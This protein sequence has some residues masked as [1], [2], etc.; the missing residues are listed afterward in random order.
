MYGCA[1]SSRPPELDLAENVITVSD[2][3]LNDKH[4]ASDIFESVRLIPLETTD[5]SIIGE[6]NKIVIIDTLI[7]IMDSK[8]KAIMLFNTK[9][10]HLSKIARKGEGPNEYSDLDDFTVMKNGDIIILDYRKILH[11]KTDGMHYKTY[12]TEFHADAI[13]SINDSLFVCSGSREKDIIVW[14]RIENKIVNAFIDYDVKHSGRIFKPLIKYMNN[15]YYMRPYTSTMYRVSPEKLTVHWFVDFGKRNI[16]E[17]IRLREDFYGIPVCL[18]SAA[19]MARFTETEHFVTFSFQVDELM[20]D[21]YSYYVYYSK[22]SGKKIITI[23]DTYTDDM[24]FCNVPRIMDA[25]S[26]EEFIGILHPEYYRDLVAKQDTAAMDNATK[27]RW[28]YVRDKTRHLDDFD[29]P[30][31][32]LYKFKEF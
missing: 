26:S 5:E 16:N 1:S 27:T 31:V 17:E 30:I 29:N 15:V 4:R 24:A 20:K 9:G 18:P 13:E 11:F 23:F 32:A 19:D 12:N 6:I 28:K 14:N 2:S 10:Q 21:G 3:E 7:Y 25:T 8:S 22:S